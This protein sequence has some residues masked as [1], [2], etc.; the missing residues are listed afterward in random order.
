MVAT[1]RARGAHRAGRDARGRRYKRA[2]ARE[3]GSRQTSASAQRV[4]P[5]A[6]ARSGHGV[7]AWR[8]ALRS[9]R[10]ARRAPPMQR[11]NDETAGQQLAVAHWPALR[12]ICAQPMTGRGARGAHDAHDASSVARSPLACARAARRLPHKTAAVV[13]TLTVAPSAVDP[14]VCLL[15]LVTLSPPPPPPPPPSPVMATKLL[16]LADTPDP[17]LVEVLASKPHSDLAREHRNLSPLQRARLLYNPRYNPVLADPAS[18]ILVEGAPTTAAF[19]HDLVSKLFP[20]LYGQP[21]LSFTS[22]PPSATAPKTIGVVLSGGPAPGGHNVICGM[23]DYVSKL[24]SKSKLLGFRSGP[25]GLLK[26]DYVQLDADMVAPYRNQG[27]FHMIGSGRTKIESPAQFEAVRNTVQELQLDALVIVGGDDSNSNAMKLAEDFSAHGLKCGVNGAPKT[28]DNDLRN[29][30]IQVS[31]GFDT[32]SK[33][34]CESVASLAFDAV[35][36]RKA[37]HFVRVM[38]RSA[39]H[40]ALECALQTHPNLCFIGEEVRHNGTTLTDI[41]DEIVTLIVARARMGKNYGVIV[42]PEGL[43]EFMPDVEALISE[44]NEILA[45]TEKTL[46]RDEITAALSATNA[47]L[48]SKLP[49]AIANQLMLERDP[50]GNVQVA[51]IEAERLLIGMASAQLSVLKKRGLYT[52][53]FSGVPH[54][55]GYEG[56]CAMPS[57]FDA[58]YTYGLGRV[59]AALCCNGKTGYVATLS[60]LT[61][62]PEEWIPAGFP[63]TMMMNIE[64]RHGKET[65]VIKKMLVDLEGAPFVE[66]AQSRESWK[67]GD[68]YRSPGTAQY[69]GP[70]ADV[71][72]LSL[73]L[74]AAA[75][76]Q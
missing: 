52:G 3:R 64:R 19:D 7:G 20:N 24:N 67:L 32:A 57:N 13:E 12:Q 21:S 14:L 72:S 63:L 66:F 8:R 54:Y 39:S 65:A 35:S 42:L 46:T 26:A 11:I 16:K 74:E 44:L 30:Q 61:K 34:Y 48:F 41:V 40:I 1:S 29:A 4:W 73:Q 47:E 62:A 55:L 23:F 49:E 15:L 2:R 51:K 22:Q 17:T 27:G 43:V 38:G 76:T 70:T 69:W 18:V 75:T 25:D 28:I 45:D 56:R 36:A 58:N 60:N 10:A 50:H 31:F 5:A 71:V 6:R 9:E 68:E 33:S 37:Y 59:A 53:K